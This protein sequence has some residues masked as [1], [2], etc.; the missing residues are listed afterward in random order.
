MTPNIDVTPVTIQIMCPWNNTTLLVQTEFI[1]HLPLA[2]K[3]GPFPLVKSVI[4]EQSQKTWPTVPP[5]N[6][7]IW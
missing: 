4:S 6:V 2:N 7:K 1:V 3:C 5:M